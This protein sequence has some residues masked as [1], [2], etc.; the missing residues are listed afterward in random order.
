MWYYTYKIIELSIHLL[1]YMCFFTKEIT[2]RIEHDFLGELQVP[3]DAYY[4]VQTMRAI[5]NFQITGQHLDKEGCL[6]DQHGNRPY[7]KG[8]RRSHCTGCR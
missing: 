2:M 3:D 8:N 5:Q 4:G 1:N 6:P 7:A